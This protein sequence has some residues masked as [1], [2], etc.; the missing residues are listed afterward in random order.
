MT[1]GENNQITATDINAI[2]NLINGNDRGETTIGD[3]ATVSAN[4]KISA[5]TFEDMADRLVNINTIHCYC[6][7]DG[8][9][10][11]GDTTKTG[12]TLTLTSDKADHNAN[13]PIRASKIQELDTDI[14]S[15]VAQCSCDTYACSCDLNCDCDDVCS[16]NTD[17]SNNTVC[18]N[19]IDCSNNTVCSN[20]T[21]CS[22][23]NDCP[24]DCGCQSESCDTEKCIACVIVNVGINC[25]CD[26]Q[27]CTNQSNTDYVCTNQTDT[28]YTCT[29]QTDSDYI[30]TNQVDC[31]CDK[32]CSC[33]YN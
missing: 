22:C 7:A 31:T 8:D 21:N 5:S 13:D 25:N 30:C 27:V 32:V 4:A 16:N 2:I 24:S 9:R 11:P 10:D 15:L 26:S 19:N 1:I 18:S 23:N 6:E 12:T 33:E 17:C 20:N 28:D 3:I 29:N 14:D